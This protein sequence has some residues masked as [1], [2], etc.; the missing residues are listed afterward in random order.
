M[1]VRFRIPQLKRDSVIVHRFEVLPSLADDMTIGRDLMAALGLVI[2]FGA[3]RNTWGGSE[4]KVCTTN[5]RSPQLTA[6]DDIL[7]GVEAAVKPLDLLPTHLGQALQ[8]CYLKLLEEYVDLYNGRLG[9]IRLNDYVFPMRADYKPMHAKPYSVPRSRE[10]TAHDE[11]QRLLKLDVIEQIYGS[12]AAAPAFFLTKSSRALRLLVDFSALKQPQTKKVEAILS[13][14]EPRSK[15]GLRRFLR[16]IVYYR[17]MVPNKSALTSHWNRLTSKKRPFASTPEDSIDFQA[18]ISALA[19]NVWLA[20]PDYHRR[21]HYD[22]VKRVTEDELYVIE[23]EELPIDG[24]IMKKHP[25]EDPTRK[26]IIERLE[27]NCA[28]PDYALRPALR[29]VLLRYRKRVMVPDSL[30]QDLIEFYHDNL[31]HPGGKKRFRPMSTFGWPNTEKGCKR[32][33]QEVLRASPA[34]LLFGDD[35][36]TRELH[37]VNWGFLFKQRFMAI[38]QENER[39]N[40]KTFY[41]VGDQVMQRIPARSRKKTDPVSKGPFIIKEV[42]DNGTARLDRSTA[43]I[44]VVF[45]RADSKLVDASV[46]ILFEDREPKSASP[47]IG[48]TRS[49]VDVAG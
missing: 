6:D 28:D 37:F 47:V 8:H 10:G 24:A 48:F 21:F 34:Q 19:P 38:L 44:S 45:S 42:F 16:M 17:E 49:L 23:E 13:I 35:M 27:H 36:I 2:D 41:H 12:E 40:M 20:F 46:P 14:A 4:M 26:S 30:C 7:I 3:G 11:I 1:V 18:V 33:R 29:T 31:P 5:H 39:E 25:L 32:L 22:H 15:K 43:S 9:K